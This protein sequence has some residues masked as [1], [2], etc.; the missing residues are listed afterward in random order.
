MTLKI[1]I[2]NMIF[3][4]LDFEKLVGAI[5]QVHAELATQASRAVNV[6]LTLRNWMIGCYIAEYEQ[7]GADRAKYGER[8]LGQLSE[9]LSS[10]GVSCVEERGLRRYRQF[11]Q[12]YPQIRETVSP[13]LHQRLLGPLDVGLGYQQ[14]D[15]RQVA[16]LG[17]QG[18]CAPFRYVEFLCDHARVGDA[19]EAR[20]ALDG[21]KLGAARGLQHGH[22]ELA[23]RPVGP[24]PSLGVV[25]VRPLQLRQPVVLLV[26]REDRYDSGDRPPELPA[27]RKSTEP[28]A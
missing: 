16:V 27:R 3:Q 18:D 13:E 28:R 10:K 12:T 7:N 14:I 4:P 1:K 11:S 24:P 2:D 25:L 17:R 23:H 20:V 8:L 5:H 21:Q 26:C 9:S 6:S 19:V 15:I 22:V